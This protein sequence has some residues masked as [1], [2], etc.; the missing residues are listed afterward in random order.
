MNGRNQLFGGAGPWDPGWWPWTFAF[1]G[2]ERERS[3]NCAECGKSGRRWLASPEKAPFACHM[4]E[5]ECARVALW[6]SAASGGRSLHCAGLAG[7][8]RRIPH[9]DGGQ[10]RCSAPRGTRVTRRSMPAPAVL[11][12]ERKTCPCAWLS[13]LRMRR[14]R[15]WTVCRP[16]VRRTPQTIHVALPRIMGLRAGLRPVNCGGQYS[17]PD[18]PNDSAK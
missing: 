12:G 2:W 5:C 11:D 8:Q 15:I 3:A 16:G 6:S 18:P 10:G 9:C 13:G 17:D 4:R 14:L 7:I 1:S